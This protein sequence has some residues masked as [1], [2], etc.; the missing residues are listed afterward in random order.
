MA[1]PFVLCVLT[2]V[3]GVSIFLVL[4]INKNMAVTIVDFNTAKVS[5]D[6]S[7]FSVKKKESMDVIEKNTVSLSPILCRT[8]DSM[9][10]FVQV[11]L[12]LLYEAD[13]LK[14]EIIEKEEGIGYLTKLVF[15]KLTPSQIAMDEV[16][17]ELT[18]KIDSLI[19][20]GRLAGLEFSTFDI[21]PPEIK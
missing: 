1:K 9:G 14:T 3:I 6:S 13:S 12:T 5:L 17:L 10:F 4:R 15:A 2:I 8:A 18:E 21:V 16:R 19:R 20:K 7:G 11:G